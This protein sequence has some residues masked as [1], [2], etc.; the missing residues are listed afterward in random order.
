MKPNRI[1]ALALCLGAVTLTGCEDILSTTP[2]TLLSDAKFWSQ[3]KD[4]IMAVNGIYPMVN[5]TNVIYRD[6]GTDNAWNQKTFEGWYPVGQGTVDASSGVASLA[7]NQGYRGIRRSN[8]LL[9]NVDRIP[10][11]DATLKERVKG[12]AKALR[13]YQYF[14]LANY[15]GDVPLI[16]DTI[17]IAASTKATRA[18]R[19]K[20]IDQVI[21]DLDEAAAVLP[22]TYAGADRGRVPKGAA[23]ALQARAALFEGRWQVAADAAKAVMDLGVYTLHPDYRALFTYAGEGS[24]ESIMVDGRLSGQRA[25]AAYQKLAPASEQG[26]S[27]I[28]P[29]RSLVDAYLMK[30]GLPIDKSPL[31]DPHKPYLN[32]D[33]RMAATLLYPG[34][35]FNGKTFDSRP[36]STTKDKVNNGDFNSTKTGY[37]YLKYVDLADRSNTTNCGIDII[38]LRYAE[39][40]LTYA[41]AKLELGQ[42]D[43]GAIAAFNQVRTRAGM[44]TVTTFTR[45]DLRRER[46]IE[47]A[48]EG[49]RFWDI[50]RWKIA[51]SVMPGTTYGVDWDEN[52]LTKGQVPGDTRKFTA[53]RDYLWPI[54]LSE[55]N[56]NPGL[57]QNPGY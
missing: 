20:V 34:A 43:A 12:E 7:W 24:S 21:K 42:V 29:T 55:I 3:E 37:Q 28:S 4:A 33:P 19:A 35:T 51:Q 39:V 32:R 38:L 8:E 41:E 2:K 6:A 10:R 15:F 44:P 18:S 11:I 48:G 40:L 30:D 14:L 47:F 31:Y 13:A 16:L 49:Q 50:R 56:L 57:G 5:D 46:R 52:D 26:V 25:W 53:P 9:A 45:D 1:L 54:P 22:T 17:D 27:S 23:L 36:T